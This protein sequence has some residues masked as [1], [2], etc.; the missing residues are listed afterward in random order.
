MSYGGQQ[1]SRMRVSGS[2]IA[3]MRLS[4]QPAD[5][6]DKSHR[7]QQNNRL[8]QLSA[9]RKARWPNT[10]D[11][12]RHHKEMAFKER[13]DKL[14]AERQEVDKKEALLQKNKRMEAIER[15]NSLLYEQTD[16]MKQLRSKQLESDVI[17]D[18]QNQVE[19][20]KI[21]AGMK[22]QRDDYFVSMS[23]KLR[24]EG[25]KKEEEELEKRQEQNA[26]IAAQQQEQLA[27]FKENYICGLRKEKAEGEAI[28]KKVEADQ[29]KERE[30][31]QRRRREAKQAALDTKIANEQLRQIRDQLIKE[32]EKEE[33][34]RKIQAKEKEQLAGRRKAQGK[35]RFEEK[36]AIKQRMID[37]ATKQLVAASNQS[38]QRE[39]NQAVELKA[40]E[41]AEM[42]RRNER[43][44]KQQ[45]AIDRSR[46]LQM[47]MRVDQAKSQKVQEFQMAQYYKKR[48]EQVEEEESA[49]QMETIARNVQVRHELQRQVDEK[50]RNR[51]SERASQLLADSKTKDMMDEENE[52]FVT[53]A[54]MEMAE[55]AREGKNIICIN[56]A[57]VAQDKSLMAAGGTRV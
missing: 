24:V 37:A 45:Q 1:K 21:R 56:K 42:E 50:R 49:E 53:L 44:R 5:Q 8:K 29:L 33:D 46:Q 54:K 30:E 55:A 7:E 31:A 25:D 16:K 23:D 11:A 32:E 57:V 39:E 41:D 3:R 35:K 28:K 27:I 22:K 34:V 43:R 26:L 17:F 36:L 20:R 2:E 6:R 38:D 4:V 18:R 47:K 12:I 48:N 19:E 14:E 10:L 13:E 40:A 51:M 52:R 9:D 15:A